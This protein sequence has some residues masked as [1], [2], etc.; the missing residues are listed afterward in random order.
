MLDATNIL[1][2]VYYCGLKICTVFFRM[3]QTLSSDG[4]GR[5]RTYCAW[6]FTES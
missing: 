4:K 6:P 5:G 1:D 3:D 2:I